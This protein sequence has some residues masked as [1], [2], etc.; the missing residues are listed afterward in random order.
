MIVKRSLSI[1]GHRTSI[2]IE[3]EFWAAL[4]A[5]AARG[6]Q[7]LATLVASID[8]GRAPDRNLSSAIRVFV[9][10]DAL[11]RAAEGPPQETV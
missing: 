5:I 4:K 9:L 1:R 2:S 6:R 10:R 3:D 11:E 7:P 8:D